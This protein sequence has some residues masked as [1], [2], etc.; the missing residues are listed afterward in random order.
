MDRTTHANPGK[1]SGHSK[2]TADFAAVVGNGVLV[3]RCTDTSAG[4]V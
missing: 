4:F 2:S 1:P 3:C